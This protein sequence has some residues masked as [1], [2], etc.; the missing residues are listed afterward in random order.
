MSRWT[1]QDPGRA[2]ESEAD[3]LTSLSLDKEDS[4]QSKKNTMVKL[5][6]FK[7]LHNASSL[8]IK[9][10]SSDKANNNHFTVESLSANPYLIKIPSYEFEKVS[11]G[12]F[13]YNNPVRIW[14]LYFYFSRV[15]VAIDIIFIS[16]FFVLSTGINMSTLQPIEGSLFILSRTQFI[17]FL[18]LM[19]VWFTITCL[20]G[21][22]LS[23]RNRVLRFG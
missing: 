21:N 10:I 16:L 9:S 2:K 13:T 6:T 4:I 5:Q 23:P 18:Y 15:K 20:A 12:Y 7:S 1:D 3:V 22:L 17:T 19:N 8:S 14:S 11:L